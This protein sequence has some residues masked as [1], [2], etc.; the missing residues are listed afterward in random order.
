VTYSG[1]SLDLDDKYIVKESANKEE[2]KLAK[3]ESL[4]EL[5]LPLLRSALF[6]P[7]L[8]ILR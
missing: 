8:P 3:E 6:P 7:P 5:A 1:K 4:S 2:K